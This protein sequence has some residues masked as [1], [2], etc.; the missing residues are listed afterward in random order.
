MLA[1]IVTVLASA[2]AA[3]A[4][5]CSP[6]GRACCTEAPSKCPY[7]DTATACREEQMQGIT[8]GTAC[9]QDYINSHCVNGQ[10]LLCI[11][12]TQCNCYTNEA[13]T[14]EAAATNTTAR[15]S[16]SRGGG[17][18]DFHIQLQYE[19]G[20]SALIRQHVDVGP[21]MTVALG[22]GL[23]VSLAW[24][25]RRLKRTSPPSSPMERDSSDLEQSALM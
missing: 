7:G 17:A 16:S 19:S 9:K 2:I 21:M 22:V 13:T 3:T 18:T 6:A 4:A 11:Y 24:A 23:V 1:S 14:D 20:R 10:M 5:P 15:S 12:A 8:Y 25:W